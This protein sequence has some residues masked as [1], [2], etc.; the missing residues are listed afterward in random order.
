MG[1]P[2][3]PGPT[4][5]KRPAGPGP[6]PALQASPGP[7]RPLAF[8]DLFDED[9]PAARELAPPPPP[10]GARP[11]LPRPAGSGHAPGRTPRGRA[12][13]IPP[14]NLPQPNRAFVGRTAELEALRQALGTGR[15]AAITQPQAVTGLGGIG[16]T[17]LA[18]AYAYAHLADYDLV[19]WLRAE[20]P[21]TLAADYAALAP[22]L[23]LDPATPDQAAL[24][25]AIRAGLERTP[26]WL[27][28]FDNAPGP[29]ELRPYLP[30][31]GAGHVLVT[32][33]ERL[34]RGTAS[35]LELDLLPTA[36][37]VAL[38]V[39]PAPDP[40]LRAE[41]ERLAADLD[42]LPLALAQARA[43]LDELAVDIPTYRQRLRESRPRV[44]AHRPE[45]ADY[46][47]S[48]ATVW[49]A[50]IEAAEGRCAAARPLLELLAFLAPDAIPRSLLG[51]DP[52][53]LPEPLRDPA[54]RDAAIGALHRFSLLRADPES[55]TIHRLVQAVTRDALDGPPP[56]RAPRRPSGSSTRRCRAR[57]RSTPTGP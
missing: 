1:G 7:A 34:W 48:V 8:R 19:R 28:V 23:G 44:L 16:K 4:S 15:P 43:Y 49:Q 46:P 56:E 27:L 51:A 14:H 18:L 55:V 11:R 2:L 35:P 20:E 3:R 12:F 5:A 25:A 53:A 47:H 36:D 37:A 21:A 17:Q 31:T 41:A 39:G 24:I 40:A 42:H 50:S 52:E 13:P 57:P 26:R 30:P 29:A 45:D 22:A 9:E 32:S 6:R 10:S 33:R 54:E 38:L